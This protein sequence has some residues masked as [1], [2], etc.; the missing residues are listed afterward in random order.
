MWGS[1]FVIVVLVLLLGVAYETVARV[2]SARHYPPEGDFLSVNGRRLHYVL[3]Q[4]P[5]HVTV[6]FE[7]GA[8]GTLVDWQTV[9]PKLQHQIR[10]CAYDRAGLGLSDYSSPPRN[11]ESILQ[12]LEELLGA[13][14]IDGPVVLVG[15]SFGGFVAQHFARACPER[16]KGLVLVDALHEDIHRHYA[17]ET[18]RQIR[19]MRIA[20]VVARFGLLRALRLATAPESALENTAR[21]MAARAYRPAMLRTMANEAAAMGWNF[22][23]FNELPDVAHDLPVTVLS[24]SP[25]GPDAAFEAKWAEAQAKLTEACGSARQ[26]V[27]DTFDHYIQ[28]AQPELVA[29]E[30]ERLV[31]MVDAKSLSGDE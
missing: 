26:V 14:S 1:A 13:L 19:L 27:A 5:S 2:R 11:V 7:S 18:A 10:M 3:D 24:R 12:D 6:I 31:A 21:V 16:V 23:R 8:G 15:H 25:N 29:K 17:R 28:F 4:A 20:A 30:I 9:R 22:R